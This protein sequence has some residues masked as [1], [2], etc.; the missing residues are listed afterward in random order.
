MRD[1]DTHNA[2]RSL[3]ILLY[4]EA[5]KRSAKHDKVAAFEGKTLNEFAYMQ[6]N[7]AGNRLC[8]DASKSGIR[9]SG[10][11]SAFCQGIVIA[12]IEGIKRRYNWDTVMNE[13]SRGL[14]DWDVGAGKGIHEIVGNLYSWHVLGA[15]GVSREDHYV[16]RRIGL[17]RGKEIVEALLDLETAED[18]HP[19]FQEFVVA[20]A[21]GLYT[22][23]AT[24]WKEV[25]TQELL[26]SK[27]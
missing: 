13:I 17:S 26:D 20:F 14:L 25:D 2:V 8:L 4:G 11:Q 1:Y 16:V 19:G 10:T 9:F 24:N 6:G 5:V 12:A 7:E 15:D 22:T 27:E 21:H 23:I 18:S 3:L